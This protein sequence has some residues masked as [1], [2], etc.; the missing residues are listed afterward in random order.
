MQA[1]LENAEEGP[2]AESMISTDSEDEIRLTEE[3]IAILDDSFDRPT[4]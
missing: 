2:V 4:S 1:L 3:E